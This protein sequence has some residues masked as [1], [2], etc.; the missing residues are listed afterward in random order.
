MWTVCPAPNAG[1]RETWC[2]VLSELG[3]SAGRRMRFSTMVSMLGIWSSGILIWKCPSAMWKKWKISPLFTLAA[4][5]GTC[6]RLRASN[7]VGASKLS[8]PSHQ[9]SRTWV[10]QE[11]FRCFWVSAPLKACLGCKVYCMMEC[12][13]SSSWIKTRQNW[14]SCAGTRRW[15][16][17][18]VAPIFKIVLDV[19]VFKLIPIQRKISYPTACWDIATTRRS[20]CSCGDSSILSTRRKCT[21]LGFASSLMITCSPLL[22]SSGWG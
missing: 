7:P 5:D 17:K 1:G 16:C 14:P 21:F 3:P 12:T 11:S 4:F 6:V 2:R 10:W 22:G 15:G 13:S 9:R 8:W 20:F 18:M 19:T